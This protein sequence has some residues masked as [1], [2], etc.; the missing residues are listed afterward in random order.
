MYKLKKL[1]CQGNPVIE[2]RV[3]H[4]FVKTQVKTL[5]LLD[6]EPVI[7]N[8]DAGSSSSNTDQVY[9]R[10]STVSPKSLPSG[11]N[12]NNINGIKIR[13]QNTTYEQN[14]N[15]KWQNQNLKEPIFQHGK[16]PIYLPPGSNLVVNQRINK[17]I[18]YKNFFPEGHYLYEDGELLESAPP[19]PIN[20][21]YTLPLINNPNKRKPKRQSAPPQRK[22]PSYL[23]LPPIRES[24]DLSLMGHRVQF[25]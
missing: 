22:T 5:E 19:S 4:E 24:S 18:S 3:Y 25:R 15:T 20:Y 1:N 12:N 16:R 7:R 21:S 11:S 13:D 2:R 9:R 14:V 8:S 17:A 6:N 23:Y 10:L